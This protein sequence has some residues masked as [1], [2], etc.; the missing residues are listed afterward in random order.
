MI[1]SFAA[2]LHACCSCDVLYDEW[3]QVDIAQTNP[4][5]WLSKQMYIAKNVIVVNSLGA[6]RQ[7]RGWIEQKLYVPDSN[8]LLPDVFIPAIR[9]IQ[10]KTY[11]D[12]PRFRCFHVSFPYTEQEYILDL[13]CGKCY[14]LMDHIE[15]LFLHVHGL[16]K[17]SAKGTM[18]ANQINAKSYLDSN[19]GKAL[20]DAIEEACGY[21]QE[22]SDWFHKYFR[23]EVIESDAKTS[24]LYSQFRNNNILTAPLSIRNDDD[25]ASNLGSSWDIE[26]G[27]SSVE[28]TCSGEVESRIGSPKF[29]IGGLN[30]GSL[31]GDSRCP[32]GFGFSPLPPDD[33]D[34]LSLN[35]SQSFVERVNE[36]NRQFDSG[37]PSSSY[38]FRNSL[39]DC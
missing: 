35:G 4:I 18:F 28:G 16:T 30:Y 29:G 19:E 22:H 5:D 37:L 26:N 13:S 23:Q 31:L 33:P 32:L 36:L 3:S 17:F 12:K 39:S 38:D 10:S 9:Q 25:D 34:V 6:Y 2:F 1:R 21:T 11:S 7:H 14:R 8:L 20:N 27:S 15:D 24:F